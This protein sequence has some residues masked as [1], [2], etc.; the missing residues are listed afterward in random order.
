MA[1]PVPYTTLDGRPMEG[2]T[3]REHTVLMGSLD[4]GLRAWDVESGTIGTVGSQ[5]VVGRTTC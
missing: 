1:S 4:C 2:T 5:Y 3:N